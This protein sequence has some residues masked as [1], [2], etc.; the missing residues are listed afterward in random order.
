MY[1]KL[2]DS[3]VVGFDLKMTVKICAI[4]IVF[5]SWELIKV[6]Q[7]VSTAKQALSE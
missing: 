1:E 2:G 5:K 7:L 3:M 4:E 6:H